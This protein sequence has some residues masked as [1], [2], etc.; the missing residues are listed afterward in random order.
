[1]VAVNMS[2]AEAVL[3]DL[4]GTVLI[5]SDRRLDGR[6]VRGDLRLAGWQAVVVERS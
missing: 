5:G 4:D 1:V 2:D 6:P 3:G